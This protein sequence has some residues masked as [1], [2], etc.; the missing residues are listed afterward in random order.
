MKNKISY[1]AK[2]AAVM[3]YCDD[4]GET[5]LTPDIA[6]EIFDA[7]SD[8]PGPIDEVLEKFDMSRWWLLDSMDNGTWWESLVRLALN[9]DGTFDHFEFPVKE[10]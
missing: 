9:I 10:I 6:V 8:S 1:A 2:A 7:L 3:H 4:T 5:E